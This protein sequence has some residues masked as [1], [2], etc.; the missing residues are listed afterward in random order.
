M[1]QI[2]TQPLSIDYLIDY[3][4][5]ADIKYLDGI[6]QFLWVESVDGQGSIYQMEIRGKKALLSNSWNVRGNLNYGGGEFDTGKTQFVFSEKKIN[7]QRTL[8][9]STKKP[10]NF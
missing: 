10:S 2:N 8:F 3:P 6:D 7:F 1:S 9:Y 5:I 4:N